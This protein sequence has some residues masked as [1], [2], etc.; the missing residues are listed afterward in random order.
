MPGVRGPP[1]PPPM[2]TA[3]PPPPRAPPSPPAPP[4]ATNDGVHSVGSLGASL[5]AGASTTEQVRTPTAHAI[6]LCSSTI[7]AIASL[8]S[9]AHIPALCL[10]IYSLTPPVIF[11]GIC[12]SRG[13]PRQELGC[14]QGTPIGSEP[15]H[16]EV[17]CV[18]I[19]VIA[20]GGMCLL[21][22][23]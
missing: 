21:S 10:L 12:V 2:A 14:S 8:A 23:Y 19:V 9:C 22:F 11:K 1:A 18:C 15:S 20:R 4:A 13:I 7:D 5:G 6:A 16:F 3:P 17:L